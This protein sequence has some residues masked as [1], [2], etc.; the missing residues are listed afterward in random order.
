MLSRIVDHVERHG[1][2]P[3]SADRALGLD[4]ALRSLAQKDMEAL[5]EF[6]PAYVAA[7]VV[8][9]LCAGV[10]LANDAGGR[11]RLMRRLQAI[12]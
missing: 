11:S 9:D 10:V 1:N 8:R 2:D 12:G 5:E 7:S 6:F 4:T 3:A